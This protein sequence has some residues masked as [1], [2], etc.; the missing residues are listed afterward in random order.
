VFLKANGLNA[1]TVGAIAHG[2]YRLAE[3][4]DDQGASTS[5]NIHLAERQIPY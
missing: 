2:H 4:I 5:L 1:D 3:A